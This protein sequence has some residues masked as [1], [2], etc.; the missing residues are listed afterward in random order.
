MFKFNKS[1]KS[2]FNT[3]LA[4]ISTFAIASAML[5]TVPAVAAEEEAPSPT[6]AFT[7]DYTLDFVGAVSGGVAKKVRHLDNLDIAADINLDQ[8][9][10]WKGGALHL[11]VSNTSGQ[12]PSEDA[13][14]LQG[15]DGNEVGAQRLR[16]Y[17][18]YFEQSFAGDRANLR[19]GWSDVSGE[20]AVADA[21]G[22][23]MN[24]SFGI[25]PEL[26]GSG[27]QGAAAFPS[28]ALT[29]RLSIKPT[30]TTYG[31]AA[32][33]NARVGTWGDPQGVETSFDDGE[34]IIAEAGWTGRGKVA[35]G[36][37]GYTKKIEDQRAVNA[38]GDPVK[39][40]AQGVYAVVEQP[41]NEP[42]EGDRAATAFLRVGLSDGDTQALKSSVQ[43]GV[44]I[45]AV[46]KGRP[47]SN[48]SI[49]ITQAH[50]A[51]SYRQ[52]SVDAGLPLSSGETV[53]ELSYSDQINSRV[54]IQPDIQYIQR[55]SGDRTIK[56]A[57]VVGLRFNL[58]F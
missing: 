57:V 24:P 18:A 56:D 10:G 47:D 23:L 36:L 44:S 54:R 5:F 16:L 14:N 11:E 19:L 21:S 20:F 51:K 22:Y 25:A 15:V 42:A 37:W 32:V 28:T 58:A 55:P 7:V 38:A 17:Q 29:A 12:T 34:L 48:L 31:L 30:E 40:R 26:A 35:A 43:A 13:G 9:L 27:P 2:S 4:N 45:D 52:N 6:V 33:V 50:L 8:G 39:R 3:R 53:F 41:L 46:V 49:G 1:Q